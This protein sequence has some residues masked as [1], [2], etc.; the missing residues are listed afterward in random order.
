MSNIKLFFLVF[1]MSSNFIL[2]QDM[3]NKLANEKSLYLKQHATNPVNWYPWGNQA[4]DSAKNSDKLLLISVG[5]SSCHWCHVMEEESFT[6]SDVAKVMNSNFVN[7]KVD[8]EERPDLDE[9]YM[10]ALVLMTGSGG[11]PMNIIALPDGTPIWGGTYVPKTQWIQVLNQVS[12][13]YKT[14]KSDVLEYANSVR[15]GVKKEAL[16]KPSPRNET[17]STDLQIELAEKAFKYSDK[18]NGGIGN[19]QKFPLPSMLNFFLRFSNEY[20]NQDMKDFVYTTLMKISRGGINDRIDG[21]FHRYTVDNTWHI[22]HFEK[23]L[24]DN[25]QLL[26]IYSNAFKV[27]KDER[28]KSELYNIH[29]FLESKMTGEDNLIYSSISADTNYKDGTKSEGD[30]YVWEAEELK[31]ILKDDFKWVSEYYN[32]NQTGYWENDRYVFYQTISDKEY[33]EQQGVNLTQFNKKL[34]RINSLLKIEREKR[35]HPIIDSKIIF[36]WNALTIRGLV[37]SYKTTK[38]PVFLNKA[39]LINNSLSKKMIDKNIIQHTSSSAA[40]VLFFEDYSYYIDAL[41]GLYE[42]TF[43]QKYLQFADELVVFSNEKFKEESGFYRF[44]T[45]QENLFADS[46]INLQDGVTPSANSVMNFNLFR[47]GHF[48]GNKNYLSQSKTMINNV[49]EVIK[50]RVTDHLLWLNNSHNYSQKFYE[51]AISGKNALVKA[52]ELMEKYLPNTI[53]AAS[54]TETNFYLLKDRYFEDETYI[55]VCVDNTC[56]FPV[57]SVTEALGLMKD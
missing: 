48:N 16:V 6:D 51:I 37:D 14:R 44:S 54:D 23:M 26:S 10:K 8:R 28:F 12:G 27:F 47:L 11:W 46:L 19:G 34:N 30:F 31:K 41:I 20:S 35:V 32:I 13:F 42:I 53:T 39:L 4:L 25:A 40:E 5:Y 55:Y 7:I 45:N 17:Y 50:E 22:P 3:E 18:I 15:E 1:I 36:S 43:D 52:N 24:Y 2:S 38:D 49:S 56:K 29:R 9:I 21:G 57:T 33:C